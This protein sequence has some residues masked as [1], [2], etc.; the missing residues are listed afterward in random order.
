MKI[1]RFWGFWSLTIYLRA[2]SEHVCQKNR[3]GE[4]FEGIEKK[5][6]FSKF[7]VILG[8]KR[9]KNDPLKGKMELFGEPMHVHWEHP[10][11]TYTKRTVLES[12]LRV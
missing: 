7:W 8:P 6:I 3:L 12:T 10:V 4:Y 9:P 11:S 1:A 2:S 5:L